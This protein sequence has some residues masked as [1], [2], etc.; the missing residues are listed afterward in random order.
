MKLCL[1]L[2]VLLFALVSLP[3]CTYASGT[4]TGTLTSPSTSV[5]I[6][7]ASISLSLSQAGVDVTQTYN[8]ASTPVI[9]ATSPIGGVVG[10]KDPLIAIN[11]SA[12]TSTGSLSGTYYVKYVY[13][14]AAGHV[15]G[16]SPS[17]S[18]IV[19]SPNNT[20]AINAPTLHPFGAVG[21]KI[22]AGTIS[23]SETLQSSV[24]GWGSFNLTA[25]SA[26]S[27]LPTNTTT[28]T[29][30]FNDAII[31]PYTSYYVAITTSAGNLVSGFPQAWYLTGSTVNIANIIPVSSQNVR[32]Q[33]PILS[34]PLSQYATQSINSP[35][36]L[37]GF[38]LNTG[39]LNTTGHVGFLL[40]STTSPT[41]AINAGTVSLSTGSND[42]IGVIHVTNTGSSVITLTFGTPFPSIPACIVQNLISANQLTQTTSV[43]SSILTGTT[44]SGDLIAY[45]C[46]RFN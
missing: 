10:I 20:I 39:S 23:G 5:P 6:G 43:V 28:C 34:N 26:G 18:V 35:L 2:M 14:D 36:T 19:N 11:A 40:G 38:T 22:Y 21:Y 4:I 41:V 25:Y 1:T 16:P 31:P 13:Y 42:N 3:P 33:N 15:T 46:F 29:L 32:F 8:L 30:T 9:C 17:L 45:Q 37:N 44:A 24:S 7:N 12:I 27:A